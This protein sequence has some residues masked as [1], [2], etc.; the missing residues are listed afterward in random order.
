MRVYGKADLP[1][2]RGRM[3]EAGFRFKDE[4]GL[5]TT[6]QMAAALG[7]AESHLRWLEK[8]GVVRPPE[9][10]TANRRKWLKRD[11]AKFKR[12]LAEHRK[13]RLAV[14]GRGGG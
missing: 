1:D 9:R 4:K 14:R 11:I 7:V 10:D 2:L 5:L 8:K 6:K 12:Q 13:E 3:V